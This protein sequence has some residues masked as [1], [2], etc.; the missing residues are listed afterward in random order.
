MKIS[1]TDQAKE[2]MKRFKGAAPAIRLSIIEGCCGKSFEM[3]KVHSPSETDEVAHVDD[4]IFIMGRNDVKIA[5]EITI[6]HPGPIDGFMITNVHAV[7]GCGCGR[8][9]FVEEV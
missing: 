5:P 7:G 1:V 3:N 4:I 6:D 9:F 8:S 2:E